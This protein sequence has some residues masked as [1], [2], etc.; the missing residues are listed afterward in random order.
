MIKDGLYKNLYE[1]FWE[2]NQQ[3][4][5]RP[6][7]DFKRFAIRVLTNVH[8][9][10]IQLDR[11]VPDKPFNSEGTNL[12]ETDQLFID[13]QTEQLGLTIGQVLLD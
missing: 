11:K 9:T 3:H 1:T 2:I 6:I 12:Q 4:L 13:W 10:Y 5:L 8:H 7:A